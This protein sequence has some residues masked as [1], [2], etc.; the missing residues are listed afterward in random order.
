MC[1]EYEACPIATQ[2]VRIHPVGTQRKN[3]VVSTSMRRDHVASTLIRRH[4]DVVCLLGI[5]QCVYTDLPVVLN[6]LP[7]RPHIAASMTMPSSMQFH[8]SPEIISSAVYSNKPD[9]VPYR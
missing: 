7:S 6:L 1:S 4:F 3:D 5:G 2:S 8:C 9:T